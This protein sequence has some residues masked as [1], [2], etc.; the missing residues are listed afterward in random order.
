MRK[1]ILNIV[2]LNI[3]A[4]PCILTFNDIDQGLELYN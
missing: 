2:L 4:A 1:L 3:L